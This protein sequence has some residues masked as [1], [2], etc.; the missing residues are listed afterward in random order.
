MADE[1]EAET[2]PKMR[3]KPKC[4]NA[5]RVVL[6]GLQQLREW[7]RVPVAELAQKLQTRGHQA[8]KQ[9][10][11]NWQTGGSV[12]ISTARA[13]AEILEVSMEDLQR[14]PVFVLRNQQ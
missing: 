7:R 5:D 8:T 12:M 10:V 11:Y 3:T 6:L 4:R 14:D 1:M 9:S 2:K 13:I